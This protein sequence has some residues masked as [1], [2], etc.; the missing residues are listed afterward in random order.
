YQPFSQRVSHSKCPKVSGKVSDTKWVSARCPASSD[1]E[2]DRMA[3]Q[4]TGYVY[5]DKDSGKWTARV[6]FTDARGRKR[7]VRRVADS[8]TAAN[9]LLRKLLGELETKGDSAIDAERMTF[10][11]LVE[12]YRAFKVKPAEYSG[13]RKTGG[14]RS[15]KSVEYRIAALLAYFGKARLRHITPGELAQIKSE[16][17]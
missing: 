9:K 15:V 14:L 4:R 3:N 11:E 1:L 17:V 16:R 10:A 12:K 13:N 2:T 6:T 7:N 8:E 5:E